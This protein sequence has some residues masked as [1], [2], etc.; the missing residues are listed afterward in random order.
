[1]YIGIITLLCLIFIP[2]ITIFCIACGFVLKA[3]GIV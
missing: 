1:M 3:C 2:E